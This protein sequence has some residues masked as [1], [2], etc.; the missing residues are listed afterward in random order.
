MFSPHKSRHISTRLYTHL[1][2][3]G[4]GYAYTIKFARSRN[5]SHPSL[6][7]SSGQ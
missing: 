4:G 7:T 3:E 1:N 2:R 6:A 5:L